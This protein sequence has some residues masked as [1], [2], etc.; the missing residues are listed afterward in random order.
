MKSFS[1]NDYFPKNYTH[2]R[3]TFIESIR[4]LP[5][6]IELG[7]WAIPGKS[8]TDLFVDH[9]WFS[10]LEKAENLFVLSSGIHGSETYA[11]AAVQAMF[12][13]EILP[14][15]DRRNTGIF[16]VHAMNPYGFKHHQR[17]TE[18]G[19]NLNRNFSVSGANFKRRNE[20]S[21][22]LCERFLERVPV[23]SLR[24]SLLEK[25]VMK[26]GKPFFDEISMDELTK[27]TAPGQFER[28]ENWE[29]G[30]HKAEPQT[31]LFIEKL[32]EIMPPFKKIIAFDLHT[33]LGDR[34]RL[35]LLMDEPGKSDRKSVV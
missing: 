15:I 9:A 19:V 5:T 17:C 4:R 24:S 14:Q 22:R 18:G 26:N 12:I 3:E 21:G 6:E 29:F 30:G 10:P 27:I 20:D 23:K 33:G 16:I 34:N 8:D 28:S 7:Q 31:Q 11:G 13:N 2:S 35:H 1:D 25:M 32:S